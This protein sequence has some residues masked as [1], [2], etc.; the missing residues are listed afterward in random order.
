MS[1]VCCVVVIFRRLYKSGCKQGARI[2]RCA[3]FVGLG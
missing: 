2:E 3:R 1:D